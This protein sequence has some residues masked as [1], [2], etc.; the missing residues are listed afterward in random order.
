MTGLY[1]I[2]VFLSLLL[3]D[4]PVDHHSF[5]IELFMRLAGC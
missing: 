2:R 4:V 1:V 3:A 5:P